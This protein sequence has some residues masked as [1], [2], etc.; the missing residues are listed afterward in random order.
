M[1]ASSIEQSA[2]R[3]PVLEET[4]EDKQFATTLA[5]G[6]E[7]L[8]CFTPEHPVLGNKDLSDRTGLPRPTISRFTYTLVKLGYLRPSG[9]GTKYQLGSAAVSLGYP[10][11]ARIPI[12]QV[13]RPQMNKLAEMLGCSVSMGIRDRLSIVYV[14]TSRSSAMFAPQF[15]DI[16]LRHPIAVSSIGHAYLAACGESEREA[17]LN[18]IRVKTPDHWNRYRQLIERSLK[19][20]ARLGFCMLQQDIHPDVCAV[21]VPLKRL[22]DGELV[23]FNC[24]LNVVQVKKGSLETEIGPR[25]AAMVRTL[26]FSMNE[27]QHIK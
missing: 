25:L 20:F 7:I 21:G 18:E 3:K 14:E 17:I 23:V 13:A 9:F 5:R 16:G 24:V 26:E 11:L 27:H 1:A 6:L 22:L 8:D 4:L 15:S 19:D 12:R 2:R 10:I